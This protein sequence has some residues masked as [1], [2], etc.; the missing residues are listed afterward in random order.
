MKKDRQGLYSSSSL[1]FYK[2]QMMEEINDHGSQYF[3]DFFQTSYS[4]H[5]TR[6]VMQMMLKNYFGC[7]VL[8]YL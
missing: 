3:V 8:H 1:R 4:D 5:V 6:Y 7:M 2:T